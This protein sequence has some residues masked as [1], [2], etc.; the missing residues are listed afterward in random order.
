MTTRRSLLLLLLA[1]PLTVVAY[2][3][4]L[5]V[6]GFVACGISGCGG[7]GF[8]PSYQPVQAQV[9]LFVAGLCWLPLALMV[10]HRRLHRHRAAGGA[11][12][13]VAGALLAMAVLGLSPNGCPQ[14]QSRATAGDAAFSPGSPTCSGDR[15]ALRPPR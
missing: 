15:N 9:G 7:G 11:A 6:T 13:V 2:D 8:G 4:A 10:L 1:V 5:V 3:I 12:A 14:G